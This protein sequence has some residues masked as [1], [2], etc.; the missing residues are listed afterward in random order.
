MH[1]PYHLYEFG[2]KSFEKHSPGAGYA[3]AFHEYYPCAT[4]MARWLARPFNAVMKWTDTGMQLAVWLR[5]I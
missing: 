1:T 5:K 4:N 2:L 3:V